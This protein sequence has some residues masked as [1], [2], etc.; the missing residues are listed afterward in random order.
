M[1]TKITEVRT[2]GKPT[3]KPTYW[4]YRREYN[5][6]ATIDHV[7]SS[8]K[9]LDD[10]KKY[11]KSHASILRSKDS[12][13]ISRE[14]GTSYNGLKM[15]DTFDADFNRYLKQK[16][17]VYMDNMVLSPIGE[18][19]NNGAYFSYKANKVIKG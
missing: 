3:K 6:Y 18:I 17:Y 12:F 8:F 7:V 11:A 9:T 15:W 16:G 10:A 14:I 4:V 5:P 2:F 19:W 1:V 13:V